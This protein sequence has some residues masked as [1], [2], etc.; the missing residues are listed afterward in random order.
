MGQVIVHEMDEGIKLL[1]YR[2]I[3]HSHEFR[4]LFTCRETKTGKDKQCLMGMG[5]DELEL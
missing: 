1:I 5:T 2:L 4:F 3:L